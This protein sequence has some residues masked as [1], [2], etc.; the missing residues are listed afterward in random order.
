MNCSLMQPSLLSKSPNNC[1]MKGPAALADLYTVTLGIREHKVAF[2][3]DMSNFY[4]SM[5]ADLSAQH[6]RRVV[7]RFGDQEAEPA[8][9]VTTKV[10]YRDKPAG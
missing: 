3:K 4:Q 9:Y 6:M 5:E 1:L 8:T 7:W 2:T 10:N